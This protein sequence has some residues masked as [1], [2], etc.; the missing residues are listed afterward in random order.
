MSAEIIHNSRPQ[1]NQLQVENVEVL[2]PMM[3]NHYV[4]TKVRWLRTYVLTSYKVSFKLPMLVW[5]KISL[6]V[7][8]N[9]CSLHF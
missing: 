6:N 1:V 4:D 2:V 9:G 8:L 5:V 3:E 7:I